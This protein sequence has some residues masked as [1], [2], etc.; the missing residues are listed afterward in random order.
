MSLFG[1]F[2]F[3]PPQKK[4]NKHPL[5]ETGKKK[6]QPN[7]G[8]TKHIQKSLV[9]LKPSF[10]FQNMFMVLPGLHSG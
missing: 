2:G 5:E 7:C 3:Q 1:L 9:Q 8:K 4:R 10:L 6:K